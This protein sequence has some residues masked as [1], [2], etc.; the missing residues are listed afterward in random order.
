VRLV[1]QHNFA[2]EVRRWKC[3]RSHPKD[4]SINGCWTWC[5]GSCMQVIWYWQYNTIHNGA[6]K[7]LWSGIRENILCKCLQHMHTYMLHYASIHRLPSENRLE[8]KPV[9]FHGVFKI[10]QSTVIKSTTSF[11][12]SPYVSQW[13]K[14]IHEFL[15]RISGIRPTLGSV[16][17][18][19]CSATCSFMFQVPTSSGGKTSAQL[20]T[21]TDCWLLPVGRLATEQEVDS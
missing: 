1:L 21:I 9:A 19:F 18:M 10:Y 17:H 11:I 5:P 6:L 13:W 14:H 2:T 16:L 12:L 4:D 3:E 20:G 8:L 7:A 15:R